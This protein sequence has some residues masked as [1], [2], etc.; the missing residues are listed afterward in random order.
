LWNCRTSHVYKANGRKLYT[1]C[2]VDALLFPVMLKH[3]AHIESPDPVGGDKIQVTV[4]PDGVQKV[5]P[6][7]AVGPLK[8]NS[9]K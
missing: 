3:T 4:T 5:K 1:R 7:S 2:A 6:E 8:K 9:E